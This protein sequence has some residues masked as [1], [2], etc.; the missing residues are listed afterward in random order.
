MKTGNKVKRFIT[1]LLVLALV[2]AAVFVGVRLFEEKK[3]NLIKILPDEADMRISDFV[4]TEVGQD[5]IQWEVKAESAQYQKKKNLALF[6]RVRIKL[7]TKEGRVF[8]MSGDRAEMLTDK[9]DVEIKGS[10]VI[11]ADTGETFTT[12]TLRYSDARKTIYTDSPVLMESKRI[13]IQG[14]GLTILMTRGELIVP[15][16]VKAKIH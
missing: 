11:T 7:T 6:E 1:L 9:K 15:S 5:D 3:T 10:V 8:T 4:Y 2:A 12:D 13:R 14:V 16:S